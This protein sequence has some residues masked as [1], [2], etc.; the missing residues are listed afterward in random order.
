MVK[1]VKKSVKTAERTAR[2]VV[3]TAKQTAKT[4]QQ[5]AK[6][7]VKAAKLAAQASN[8]AAKAAVTTAKAAVKA[9][10][11][12]V[13][14]TIAAI[15]GLVALIAAGGWIAVLV[16]IIICLIGLLAGSVFGVFFSGEDSG[17]ANGRTMSAVISV[18][19]AEVY[20]EI[21]D[22]KNENAHD[23]LDIDSV[24]INWPEILSVYAVKV[25]TDSENPAEVVT[26][27]D[28]KVDILR[29]IFNKM[30]SLSHSIE[31]QTQDRTVTD[32]GGN[33][34]TETVSVTMLKITL[35][36]K[37]SVDMAAEYGFS[38]AQMEQLHELL[39]PK[40]SDMWATLI[41]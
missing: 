5:S 26:L 35:S 14:A 16:I 37:N 3:K 39:N 1:T 34:T 18:L 13:K 28:G 29:S 4:T 23:V 24:S 25:N 17:A 12:L 40:Y 7:A 41:Q 30:I 31:T 2:V 36:Q 33:E 22:I 38:E 6:A 9:T 15:K 21:E 19:T 20:E 8:A 27:N 11:A 10:T 32:E